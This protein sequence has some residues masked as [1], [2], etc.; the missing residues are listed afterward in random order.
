MEMFLST[1]DNRKLEIYL[2]DKACLKLF[3]VTDETWILE[4]LIPGFTSEGARKGFATSQ[5]WS[6]LALAASNHR[7]RDE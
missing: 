1:L 2:T 4:N 6:K 7:E 3:L 5:E